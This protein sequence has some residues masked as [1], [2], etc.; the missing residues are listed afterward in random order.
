M[1]RLRGK[2]IVL[3]VSGGIAAYK[4]VLL[5]R[6]LQEQGAD[7]RVM[8]THNAGYFIGPMTFEA[9]SGHPVC[10]SLFENRE[11]T[12]VPHIEWARDLDILVIAPATANIIG[13]CAGGIA[14][15]ALSTF[16]LAVKCPVVFCP[17]MNEQMYKS[18]VVQRNLEILR[19][20]GHCVLEPGV[21]KLACRTSGPGRLPEPHEIADRLYACLLNQDLEGWRFLVTAGPTREAIDP[22]RFIT[23]PST[24]KMGYAIAR[25]AEHRGATVNLVT[26]P[27][28]LP[29][30][31]GVYVIKVESAAQ[32]AQAVFEEAPKAQIV[33]KTAAVADYRPQSPSKQKIKKQSG[34]RNLELER[35]KDIL[36]VLGERKQQGQ[37]LV[38]FAAETEKLA[39]YAKKKLTEK[40]LDLIV[41]NLVGKAE[42]GFGG[43]RNQV[44]LFYRDGLVEETEIMEKEAVAHLLLDRIRDRLKPGKSAS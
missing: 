12:G 11:D 36:K 16:F 10:A 33:V 15:D 2:R 6:I 41:G 14:D 8:M 17:S 3:G 43:E 7:I 29:D 21:G 28:H 31:P 18:G 4:S 23:N 13:K 35:T 22:V 20:D 30:P 1:E 26:G 19:Q 44:T 42:S 27:T 5:L 25:A 32:M 34:N 37:F 40:N 24:G 9:I 39:E 38:G